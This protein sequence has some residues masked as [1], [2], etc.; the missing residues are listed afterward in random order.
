MIGKISKGQS[1]AGVLRYLEN[2]VNQ[3][4]GTRI[5]SNMYGTSEKQLVKEFEIMASQRP[6][7]GKPVFHASLNLAPEENLTDKQFISMAQKYMDEMGFSNNQFVVY[8]HFDREHDHIHI[9]ANRVSLNG[10]TVTDKNDFRRTETILR[11]FEEDLG[12]RTV[13]NSLKSKAKQ[14]SKGQV[15]YFRRTGIV[16][17]KTQIETIID[18]SLKQQTSLPKFVADLRKNG[19]N[20]VFHENKQKIFGIS[21][22][23]EGT[24]FKG[25]DIGRG[26]T[27]S[28]IQKQI[29]YE[30]ERELNP[31]RTTVGRGEK[32]NPRG[33]SQS[34]SGSKYNRHSGVK[35]G[36]YTVDNFP[37]G[38]PDSGQRRGAKTGHYTNSV[39]RNGKEVRGHFKTTGT[40]ESTTNFKDLFSGILGGNSSQSGDLGS[41]SDSRIK[42][43]K[44]RRRG[45]KP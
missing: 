20:V 8:R 28:Q 34:T 43:R 2:K 19:V 26:Y 33:T 17:A 27:W 40:R 15:E 42:K 32:K 23:L 45:L 7:L 25:S 1:F 38:A 41:Q 36:N 14:L 24:S 44:K 6:N 30:H 18:D 29:N 13:E 39:E 3:G 31:L 12:L 16:P 35:R 9:V 5:D 22:E 11:S 4:V 37:A 21:Y 10:R